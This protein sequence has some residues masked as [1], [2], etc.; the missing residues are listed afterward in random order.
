MSTSRRARLA[1]ATTAAA[2][3]VVLTGCGVTGTSFQPGVAAQVDDRT[4]TTDHVDAVVSSYCDALKDQL[5]ADGSAAPLSYFRGGV[6][7]QLAL[8]LAAEQLADDYDVEPTNDYER[9]VSGIEA[10]TR[11]LTEEQREA[12]LEVESSSAY[13]AS[14]QLAVGAKLLADEGV[15]GAANEEAGQRGVEAFNE[16]LDTHEIEFNPEYGITIEDGSLVAVDTQLSY[17]VGEAAKAG[18][19]AEPDPAYAKSLPA[20]Q[21]CG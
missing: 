17:P 14:V 16:W 5:E 21:R 10:G 13:V 2:L 1:V 18:Q 15:G 9:T 3:T 4:V 6:A 8:V 20:S 11:Q 7:G 12:V 19:A